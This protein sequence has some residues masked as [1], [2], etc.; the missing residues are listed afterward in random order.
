M[1]EQYVRERVRLPVLR[2]LT[3]TLYGIGAITLGIPTVM[4][5][6]DVGVSF[7]EKLF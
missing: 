2:H 4:T 7:L 1:I 5:F 3:G 6:Y